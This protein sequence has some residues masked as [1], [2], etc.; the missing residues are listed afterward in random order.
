VAHVLCKLFMHSRV[1]INCLEGR[2]PKLQH[3]C[4]CGKSSTM[5]NPPAKDLMMSKW[6]LKSA[7][8]SHNIKRLPLLDDSFL[9]NFHIVYLNWDIIIYKNCKLQQVF[10]TY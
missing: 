9:A 3:L 10:S 5:P 4:K 1:T 7:R 6:V 8:F 2:R